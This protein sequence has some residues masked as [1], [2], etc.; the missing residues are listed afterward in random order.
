[1][2]FWHVKTKQHL[3]PPKVTSSYLICTFTAWA[4]S[5]LLFFFH[6]GCSFVSNEDMSDWSHSL[7]ACVKFAGYSLCFCSA[8]IKRGGGITQGRICLHL[9]WRRIQWSQQLPAGA[10][11]LK[12]ETCK[13]EMLFTESQSFITAALGAFTQRLDHF[14]PRRHNKNQ[15]I[16]EASSWEGI[17]I[18]F[19]NKMPY[20]KT[21]FLTFDVK[22]Y[23]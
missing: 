1:M 2:Y 9:G 15:N 16:Q 8:V 17:I 5:F 18:T 10:V 4:A 22:T 7:Y 3:P 23:N 20:A 6:P 13:T 12:A 21:C 14:S 19:K 11:L